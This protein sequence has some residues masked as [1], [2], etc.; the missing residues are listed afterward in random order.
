MTIFLGYTNEI[1]W[2]TATMGGDVYAGISSI[3]SE[4]AHGIIRED[5]Y[6]VLHSIDAFHDT[7]HYVREH[8]GTIMYAGTEHFSPDDKRRE[9]LCQKAWEIIKSWAEGEFGFVR[10]ALFAYPADYRM[11]DGTFTF[12]VLRD[13]KPYRKDIESTEQAMS[14]MSEEGK[15]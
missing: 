8:L 3:R 12:L 11:Y 6:A 13:G 9:E 15:P 4:M 10:M 1:E 7:V 2:R 5:V 14:A